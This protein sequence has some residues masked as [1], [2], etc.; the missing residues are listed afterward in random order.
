MWSICPVRSWLITF[1]SESWM[2]ERSAVGPYYPESLGGAR[3]PFRVTPS[4]LPIVEVAEGMPSQR[5]G[6][7][8]DAIGLD[9]LTDPCKV[10]GVPSPY[11]PWVFES[12][13]E[14]DSVLNLFERRAYGENLDFK[15]VTFKRFT[16]FCVAISVM[17]GIKNEV[18][19]E[20]HGCGGGNFPRDRTASRRKKI[21]GEQRFK[22][23]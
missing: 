17:A 15:I 11:A 3:S 16:C 10:H 12:W 6:A 7:A 1:I 13:R 8:L 19:S 23:S 4:A 5:R 20:V 9:V 22:G 18:N 21:W 2:A 14:A